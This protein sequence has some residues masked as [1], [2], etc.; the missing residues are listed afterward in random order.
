MKYAV[1]VAFGLFFLLSAPVY[2]ALLGG[3][4]VVTTPFDP[5]RHL[6]HWLVSH[7]GYGYLKVNPLWDVAV[8]G[9]E[10]IPEGPCVFTVNHQSMADVIAVLGLFHRFKF[11][12]KSSLFSVPFVGWA[13]RLARYMS[14]VRGKPHS[15][16]V[17]LDSCRAWLRRGTPVLIFPEGTYAPVGHLL[18]FKRGAFNLAVEEKVPLVPVVIEGTRSLVIE[19]G[20]WLEP[21]CRIRVRVLPA[22]LPGEL[23]ADPGLLAERVRDLYHR[24]LKL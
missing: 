7:L 20:P 1:T 5:D 4:W 11:V 14:L 8:E 6:T 22:I 21:T 17:M 16:Q 13:M 9:R 10:R 15:T 23:G 24:E 19:D 3:L 2:L 18:A 12:S